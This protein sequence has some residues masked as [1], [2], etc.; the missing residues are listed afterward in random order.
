MKRLGLRARVTLVHT[1]LFLGASTIVVTLVYLENRAGILRLEGAMPRQQVTSTGVLVN[2]RSVEEARDDALTGLLVQSILTFLALGVIAGVLGW[3]MTGRVL[4]RVHTMTAQARSIST[5]NLHDRIALTGPQDELKE[6]SDTFDDLLTRLDDAFHAQGRFIANASHE[7][8]T[9]LTV[10]RTLI[11]VGLSSSDP[12]RVQRAK[13]E[14]LRSNDRCIALINGLLQLA[15]G[16]Q[17]LHTREPVRLD[18]VVTQVLDE[19]PTSGVTVTVDL[20]NIEVLGDA[21]FLGQIF[22][23]LFENAWRY[24]VSNGTVEVQV[25]RDDSW[26]RLCVRNTG[27]IV[28]ATEVAR[29]F[30]PFQ[31]GAPQRTGGGAGLGLSIVR[32]LVTAHSG[33]VQAEPRPEGGLVVTV[34]IPLATPQRSG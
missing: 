20:A 8:R 13:D 9:P 32:A 24:N 31:R 2:E 28:P 21:L 26:G 10:I 4:G 25:D 16:E 1:G 22:R 29:L 15:Q 7:L 14:L 3:W 5:A 30:E 6:L 27:P 33:R 11:Q 19:K 23:N 17:G 34:L 18:N 12:E